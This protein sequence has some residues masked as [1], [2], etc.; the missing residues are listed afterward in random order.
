MGEEIPAGGMLRLFKVLS[1]RS[2]P[3]PDKP[4]GY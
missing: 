4:V 3:I 1:L 2:M